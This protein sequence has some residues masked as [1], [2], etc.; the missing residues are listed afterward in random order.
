MDDSVVSRVEHLKRRRAIANEAGRCDRCPPHRKENR[1]R[2]RRR[3]WKLY[4]KSKWRP[5]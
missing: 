1:V 5:S 4:R 3:T 2:P